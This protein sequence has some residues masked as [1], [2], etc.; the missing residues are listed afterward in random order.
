MISDQ[1]L[2]A[3][4]SDLPEPS[5]P[6]ELSATIL[7]STAQLAD[8]VPVPMPSAATEHRTWTALTAAFIGALV[9]FGVHA[10]RLLEGEVA[11][12]P[13][14]RGMPGLLSLPEVGPTALLLTAGLLLCLLALFAPDTE[15]RRP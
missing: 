10:Y 15:R 4:L 1:D 11:L 7:A 9:V 8:Q 12:V 13:A 3:A 5:P 2:Q 6:P 14:T